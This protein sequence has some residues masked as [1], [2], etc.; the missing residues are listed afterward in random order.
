MYLELTIHVENDSMG[1]N[2]A[3]HKVI[4]KNSLPFICLLIY[5]ANTHTI[6]I[7]SLSAC[8]FVILY[9]H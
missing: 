6:C 3:L 2:Y 9:K 1:N 4:R 8:K 5:F 7:I